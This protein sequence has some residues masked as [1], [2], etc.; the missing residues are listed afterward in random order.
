MNKLNLRDGMGVTRQA[1]DE[2]HRLL[3]SEAQ[4]L[5]EVEQVIQSL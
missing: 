5:S 3:K 2:N 4:W 1:S